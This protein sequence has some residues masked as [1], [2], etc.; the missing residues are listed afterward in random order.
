[1]KI[2]IL[3]LSAAVLAGGLTAG[4]VASAADG[5]VEREVLSAQSNYCHLKFPAIREDS[6]GTEA[7][8]RRSPDSGDL[9]DFYGPCDENPLGPDQVLRQRQENQRRHHIEYEP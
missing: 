4:A 3:F 8:V 5:V 2:G 7:P 1:V 6:L 9:I